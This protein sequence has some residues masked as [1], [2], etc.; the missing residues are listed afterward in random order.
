M[1]LSR[2]CL[3][4]AAVALRESPLAAWH[5]ARGG[6][7]VPFAG[8]SMPVE[9]GDGIVAS[10]HH[11]RRAA[12]LFDVSHMQQ[13][14]VSGARAVELLERCTPAAPSALGIDRS[15][16][17][18]I[19][20]DAGG[21]I[22]DCVV[23]RTAEDAFDIVLNASR[24]AVDLEHIAKVAAAAGI[25]PTPDGAS[26]EPIAD[27]ALIALQGPRAVDVLAS[28]SS[29]PTDITQAPFMSALDVVLWFVK[30]EQKRAKK[31][32]KNCECP[33]GWT[34]NFVCFSLWKFWTPPLAPQPPSTS[35]YE[36][37]FFVFFWCRVNSKNV[38]IR[39]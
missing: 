27:T 37:T 18:L 11:V 8:W 33:P 26:I 9:Y 38:Y 10:H 12:G 2:R 35:E 13:V 20:N 23:T 22:D 34:T 21:I 1:N 39:R 36:S 5:A 17:A 24:G 6:R 15:A 14:R 31:K 4:A 19:L 3:N 16:L 29:G 30:E 7:M 25:A 32:K 28:L